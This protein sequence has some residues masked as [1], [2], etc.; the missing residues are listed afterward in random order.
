MIAPRGV[1]EVQRA[2]RRQG[3]SAIGYDII[4]GNADDIC[5][6][7]GF[8]RAVRLATM[9]QPQGVTH[10]ATKCSRWVWV[11]RSQT[12]RHKSDVF[13]ETNPNNHLS[14]MMLVRSVLIIM[15]IV[16]L[17]GE[18]VVEQ[19]ASSLMFQ[20]ADMNVKED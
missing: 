7:E 19:P 10:W 15:L 20:V 14:N 12:Q 6:P 8:L 4:F 11:S 1:A 18:F 17:Q 9:L 2:F 5:S 16:A 3:L 13:A